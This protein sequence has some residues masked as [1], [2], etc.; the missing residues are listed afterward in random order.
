MT[1]KMSVLAARVAS[2][3]LASPALAA[4]AAADVLL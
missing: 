2:A 4:S 1:I 3:L